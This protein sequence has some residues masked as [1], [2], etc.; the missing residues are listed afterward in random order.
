MMPLSLAAAMMTIA[1]SSLTVTERLT[2]S[3]AAD[4]RSLAHDLTVLNAV[5]AVVETTTGEARPSVITIAI[6]SIA[7]SATAIGTTSAAAP[8]TEQAAVVIVMTA[9]GRLVSAVIAV[10]AIAMRGMVATI[11]PVRVTRPNRLS[12]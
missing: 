4:A 6:V 7:V 5:E 2:R 11:E 3:R 8:S 1:I 12:M 10:S 9:I